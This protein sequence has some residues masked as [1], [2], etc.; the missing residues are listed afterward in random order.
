MMQHSMAAND[1]SQQFHVNVE[2]KR[3]RMTIFGCNKDRVVLCLCCPEVGFKVCPS[4]SVSSALHVS[5]LVSSLNTSMNP[6]V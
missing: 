4:S 2:E 6:S 5:F 1:L 3:E